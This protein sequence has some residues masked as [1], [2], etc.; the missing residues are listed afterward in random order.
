MVS[1]CSPAPSAAGG[2]KQAPKN[3]TSDETSS[4]VLV[5]GEKS[6]LKNDTVV[7]GNLT[8]VRELVGLYF[9]QRVF[10]IYYVCA[11]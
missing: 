8:K 7:G 9:L 6:S 4:P 11:E 10:R 5:N 3:G 1:S 2:G